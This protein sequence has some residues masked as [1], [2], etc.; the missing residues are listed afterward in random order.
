MHKIWNFLAHIARILTGLVFMFSGM[1]KGIDPL[2]SAYKFSDYF[3]AFKLTFLDGFSLPFS[4]LLSGSEFLIGAALFF[5][6]APKLVSWLLTFYMSFF[7][8]LTLI[9]ALTNPVSDCGCFGDA[10]VITNWQTFYKNVVLMILTLLVLWRRKELG[11]NTS[12]RNFFFLLSSVALFGVISGYGYKYLP[13]IDFRPYKVGTYIP[14]N[15]KVPKGMPEDEFETKLIYSKGGVDKEFTLDNYPWQ[16]STWKW[17]ETKTILKKKGY[18]PPIHDFVFTDTTGNDFTKVMLADTSYTLIMVSYD[19]KKA[20]AKSLVAGNHFS[21]IARIQHNFKFVPVTASAPTQVDSVR[22]KYKLR[23][24]FNFADGTM[25]K[26]VIRSNP[27]LVLLH[28]GTVMAMWPAGHYP[29]ASFFKGNI[30]SNVIVLNTSHNGINLLIIAF[31]CW[32]VLLQVVI[33]FTK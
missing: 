32:L 7:T 20:A 26:T 3:H 23:Y 13:I 9:L 10:L 16:D 2:G 31:L 21:D 12:A 8:I 33:K 15:M 22:K 17:K 6:I 5:N 25:L 24:A 14:D 29:D 18:Q 30:L 4:F 27:G 19:L 11:N 28:N 1:M